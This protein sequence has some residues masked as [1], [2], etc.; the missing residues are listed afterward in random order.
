MNLINVRIYDN[1]DSLRKFPET[2]EIIIDLHSNCYY[3]NYTHIFNNY[4]LKNLPINLKKLTLKNY[5]LDELPDNSI[6]NL[7][8]L[9]NLPNSLIELN[10]IY[11]QA[12]LDNLPDSLETLYIEENDDFSY[13][14]KDFVN[15]PCGLK[16]IIISYDYHIYP[17]DY[18]PKS[19]TFCSSKNIMKI[20]NSV[21]ELIEFYKN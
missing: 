8:I 14:N 2:E 17:E 6:N 19:D 21:D 16:K 15:L 4:I 13:K 7:I 3:V 9:D 1:V 11:F 20:Y 10:L 5:S 12:N 18:D